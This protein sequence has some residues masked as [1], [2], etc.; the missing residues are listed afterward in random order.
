VPAAPRPGGAFRVFRSPEELAAARPPA[1][2]VVAVGTF[3]GVHLGHAAVLGEA[4]RWARELGAVPAALAFTRPPRSV[5]GREERTD[6]VTGPEHRA[7]LMARLGVGLVLE[8]EF[9]AELAVLSAA[10]FAERY[11]AGALA[12]RGLVLGHDARLGRGGSAGFAALREIGTLLGFAVRHVGPVAACGT[13]VSSSAVRRAILAG[14]LATAECLLGRRVSVLG[15]VVPGRGRGRELGF[16]TVNLDLHREVRPPMG[17][18]ATW[19]HVED[20]PALS[21]VTNVGFRPT[22]GEAAGP[23]LRPDL[24]VETHLLE[25]GADLYGRGVEVEFV[26][27][28]RDEQRFSS[29]EALGAQIARDVAEAR[30][31]LGTAEAQRHGG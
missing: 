3:D 6:L 18:Y 28:L 25:G 11:L 27:K 10:D 31:V 8:L 20:G 2:S 9:S 29:D 26:R 21:S 13:T 15:T 22:S 14:D 7:R 1:G 19:A 30:T 12:A 5:L 17:V 16:P 23:G 24:L 4:V